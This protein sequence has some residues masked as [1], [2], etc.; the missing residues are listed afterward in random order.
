MNNPGRIS[1]VNSLEI[2]TLFRLPN[3]TSPML[4]GIIWPQ[5]PAV[6]MRAAAAPWLSP[7]FRSSGRA[8][9]PM[10]AMVA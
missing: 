3:T 10:A 5:Q 8:I 6:A 9:R 1:A 7:C 2:D 4:G